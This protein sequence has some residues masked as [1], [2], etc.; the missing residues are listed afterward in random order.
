M[1]GGAAPKGMCIGHSIEAKAEGTLRGVEAQSAKYAAGL[2]DDL[3]AHPRP[4]PFLFESNGAVIHFTDGLDPISLHFT[5]VCFPHLSSP[6]SAGTTRLV[7]VARLRA[8]CSIALV[9]PIFPTTG[10]RLR[11]VMTGSGERIA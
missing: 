3:P 4:L 11:A 2:P 9:A 1:I 8:N 5:L 6:A 7:M 10:R